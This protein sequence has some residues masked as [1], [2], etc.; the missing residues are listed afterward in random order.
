MVKSLDQKKFRQKYGLF[1]VEGNK[2]VSELLTSNWGIREIYARSS[3]IEQNK[4]LYSK[5]VLTTLQVNEKELGRISSQQN[6]D[7][8]VAVVEIPKHQKLSLVDENQIKQGWI[9]ALDSIRDPGNL[10]TIIR[11]ADWFGFKGILCAPDCVDQFNPK[12]VR[13][14]MGSLFRVPIIN[15]DLAAGFAEYGLPVYG[16]DGNG[17]DSDSVD[18]PAS[19]ILTIGNESG[20]ITQ[21]VRE[22]CTA[23]LKIPGGGGA[24]SLNAAIASSI[25]MDRITNRNN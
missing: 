20:G 24:E 17:L 10:G 22:A 7:S 25:L 8:V 19:G 2:V 15:Q 6:P 23:M 12:V 11:S 18:L 5:K 14:A 21:A 4:A 3:W 13:A 9:L 16:A 1:R